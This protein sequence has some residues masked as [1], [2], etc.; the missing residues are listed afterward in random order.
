MKKKIIIIFVIVIATICYV[1]I[2]LYNNN[3][4]NEI[5][6]QET[7]INWENY[8]TYEIELEKDLTIDKKGIYYLKGTL[9]GTITIDTDENVKLVLEGVTITSNDG[10]AIYVKSSKNTYIELKEGTI[11]KIEDS[12]K[13]SNTDLDATIYSKDDLIFTGTGKLILTANYQD[14]I[15]S[16]D[17]LIFENGSY[18]ITTVDDAIRGK[19][20]VV[21]VDG[22]YNINAKGDGIKSTNETDSTKGYILIQ[23]GTFNIN[24]TTDGIDAKTNLVIKN[25]TFN[26]ITGGGSVNASTKE[27]WGSW[28][29][30]QADSAK[31]IKARNDIT[32]ENGEFNFDTA[33]DAIH[34]N[35]DV[36]VKEGNI[37]I[38]TGDDGIHADNTLT[39]DNGTIT[40]KSSY[41]G[42]EG[43][44]ITI[45]QGTIEIT[46]TDD[47]INAAGGNDSSAMNRPGENNYSNSNHMIEINGGT[48]Y[49]NAK[50]DGIDSN[51]NITMNDGLV[52]VN[53]PTDNGN[54]TL[55]Y[56]GTFIV[57]GGTLVAS[58]SAGM[59][60]SPSNNSNINSVM[61]TFGTTIDANTLVS[62]K[63]SDGKEVI[64]YSAEKSYQN[65]VI[66]SSLLVNGN[67]TI[68]TGG[69]STT[70]STYGL[71][72]TGGYTGGNQ[73][74][75]FTISSTNTTVGKTINREQPGQME[76]R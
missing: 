60:Q 23:N 4:K 26:I 48:I 72:E 28:G 3:I 54:G 45:N 8:P 33:D 10:P 66:T 59:A 29:T 31:G 9:N 32:I 16:K 14:G 21:I 39:I 30:N 47:G 43:S 18:E 6:Y 20:S 69:S 35:N 75:S 25:G 38:E 76:R 37:V 70:T 44:S 52:I 67:Y 2:K 24:A 55:D 41:E 19:D 56:D 46:A 64:T 17:D 57:N 40:I 12:E 27:G 7:E 50:G 51:G 36:W 73:N 71:Y 22:D 42:L 62:I 11:N 74:Q 53:G 49:I 65:L 5:E 13:H 63:D 61:I 68:Y 58:G 15:V 34:S 1:Y